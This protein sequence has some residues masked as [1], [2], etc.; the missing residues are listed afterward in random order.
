MPAP[1]QLQ[2]ARAN[3][4][5]T[6]CCKRPARPNR[7][8]CALCGLKSS[9]HSLF[10]PRR[11]DSQRSAKNCFVVG[12]DKSWIQEVLNSF[13]GRCHYTGRPIEIDGEETAAVVL[14]IP[15]FMVSRYGEAKIHHPSNVKWCHRDVVV[16]KRNMTAQDFADFWKCLNDDS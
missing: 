16:D 9:I 7:K 15:R 2:H 8:S 6:T 4:L 5:C 12:Y 11:N 13:D 3:N 10:R 1:Y 14:H